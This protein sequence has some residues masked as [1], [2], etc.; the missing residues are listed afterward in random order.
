MSRP[1]LL[2][3]TLT[4]VWANA[5]NLTPLRGENMRLVDYRSSLPSQGLWAWIQGST[6]VWRTC[7]PSLLYSYKLDFVFSTFRIWRRTGW[8]DLAGLWVKATASVEEEP[9]SWWSF[10]SHW[11]ME[12]VGETHNC[13]ALNIPSQ[14]TGMSWNHFQ[15][16]EDVLETPTAQTRN[17][18]HPDKYNR[19]NKRGVFSVFVCSKVKVDVKCGVWI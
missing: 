4:G 2:S 10:V 1:E 14:I 15:N 9:T 3:L 19:G 8:T 11:N 13:K 16:F 17:F 6:K 7:L 5:P 12:N 18:V